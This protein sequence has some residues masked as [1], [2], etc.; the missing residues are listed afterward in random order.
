MRHYQQLLA[1]ARQQ[2]DALAR[3]EILAATKL[4]DARQE[5]LRDA[6][7]PHGDDIEAIQEVLRLDRELSTAVRLEMIRIRDEAVSLQRGKQALHGYSPQREKEA[8]LDSVR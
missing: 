3:G 4:L 8:I 7:P 1:L 6:P 5:L 2:A